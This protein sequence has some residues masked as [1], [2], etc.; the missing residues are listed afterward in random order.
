MFNHSDSFYYAPNGDLTNSTQRQ[1]EGKYDHNAPMWSQ[2]DDRFFWNKYMLQDLINSNV[3]GILYFSL[4]IPRTEQPL[5]NHYW[6]VDGFEGDGHP[7]LAKSRMG[8]P[9]LPKTQSG[10]E[11]GT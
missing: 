6:V 4:Q 7:N 2:A 8:C 9:D 3:S 1:H 11:G 10:G 5:R